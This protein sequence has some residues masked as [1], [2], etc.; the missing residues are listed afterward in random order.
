MITRSGL[1]VSRLLAIGMLLIGSYGCPQP[2][3]GDT[4]QGLLEAS[5]A[6]GIDVRAEEVF[7]I[8]RAGDSFAAA[9]IVGWENVAATELRDGVDI[10]FAYVALSEPEVPA[11]YYT[12]RAFADATEVGTVDA[13]VELVDDQGEVR[14]ELPAQAEIHSLTVPDPAPFRNTFILAQPDRLGRTLIW[15]RCPNGVCIRIPI[16]EPRPGLPGPINAQ[17]AARDAL[18]QAS[19]EAGVEVVEQETLGV[20][21]AD[22]A[23]VAAP[24]AGW[25]RIPATELSNGVEFGFAYLE[26]AGVHPGYY[27]LRAFAEPTGVGTVPARVELVDANGEVSGTLRAT[28]EIHSMQVPQE[29]PFAR[30]VIVIGPD[31]PDTTIWFRCPNGVC[32]RFPSPHPRVLDAIF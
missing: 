10:A 28:A 3:S 2:D 23:L 5:A 20:F 4:A 7:S 29:L 30:T 27:T 26:G 14:A 25:E 8:S 22:G 9:P 21:G 32:I 18:V 1:S 11:G 16:F 31:G 19:A 13:R 24:V 6:A 12:L 17:S 15:L